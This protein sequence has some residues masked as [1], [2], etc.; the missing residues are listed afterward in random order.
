MEL[1]QL[2][3]DRSDEPPCDADL[4]DY[5][6]IAE[7]KQLVF[8]FLDDSGLTIVELKEVFND[9]DSYYHGDRKKPNY[10]EE[11]KNLAMERWDD[12]F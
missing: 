10:I 7:N 12:E 9:Y 8:D 6:L 5:Q 3:I 2:G 1:R 4:S 11:E